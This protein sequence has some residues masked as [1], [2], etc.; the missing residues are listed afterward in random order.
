MIDLAGL[1][2]EE[3]ESCITGTAGLATGSRVLLV[4]DDSMVRA[5]IAESLRQQGYRVMEAESAKQG[6]EML[7]VYPPDVVL[8]DVSMPEIDGNEFC[9]TVQTI[10]PG[11]PFILITGYATIDRA[12]EGLRCGALDFVSKPVS[13]SELPL[14]IERNLARRRLEAHRLRERQAHVLMEAIHA[15]AAAIDAKHPSTA[16]HSRRVAVLAGQIAEVM[17]L[18]ETDLFI[19]QLAA[20]M[21]DVG[22]IGVPDRVLFFEGPLSGED[23]KEMRR[24]PEV[25]SRILGQIS[26]LA[27]VASIVRHHHEWVNGRGYPDG[28]FGS[29]IPLMARILSVADAWDAMTSSRPYR[30]RRGAAEALQEL[31]TGA[32][33]Q[34]DQVV[35][36]VFEELIYP[37]LL[38]REG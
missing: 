30:S 29:A 28:L 36:A 15:L 31:R 18:T 14:L 9:Q 38:A 11:L 19:L 17:G 22:K 13:A 12:V 8:S 4:D 24:H 16:G 35:V 32:G 2:G 33:V 3:V 20:E 27:A 7:R 5:V 6:L 23:Q 10:Y 34:F 1:T 26:E 21:H 37:D 25:G